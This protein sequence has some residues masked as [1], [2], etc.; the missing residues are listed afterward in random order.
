MTVSQ[1][2]NLKKNNTCMLQS[3]LS[4]DIVCELHWD[5]KSLIQKHLLSVREYKS[6]LP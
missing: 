5:K 1:Q 2:K 3:I 4:V 6:L